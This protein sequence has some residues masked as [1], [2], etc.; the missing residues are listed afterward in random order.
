MMYS[1]IAVA[2]GTT[3]EPHTY[4]LTALAD[5]TIVLTTLFEKRHGSYQSL[6]LQGVSNCTVRLLQAVQGAIHVTD[7]HDT[8][9]W[10]QSHQLRLH[11]SSNLACHSVVSAGAILEDCTN[12]VFY[13]ATTTLDVRDFNWLKSGIPSPNFKIE[14]EKETASVER[15]A[16]VQTASDPSLPPSCA[17]KEDGVLAVDTKTQKRASDVNGAKAETG[18]ADGGDDDDEL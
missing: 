17:R 16:S 9:L 4:T 10:S 18:E 11:E 5:P 12:L 1:C 15:K 2:F 8:S 7:C 14:R 6:H 13:T 3:K